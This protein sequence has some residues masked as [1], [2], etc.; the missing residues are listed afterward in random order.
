MISYIV[1][2][3]IIFAIS[4]ANGGKKKVLI[5]RI[6]VNF[7]PSI[8]NSIGNLETAH[9]DQLVRKATIVPAFAPAFK[10][11]ATTGRLTYGPPG[12]SPLASVPMMIP[13]IPDSSPTHLDI[14]SVGR[15]DCTIPATINAKIKKWKCFQN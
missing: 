7:H 1:I 11:P 9:N 15:S 3:L 13:R 6:R 4:P 10:S 5:K 8:P 12:V 2:L 14:R